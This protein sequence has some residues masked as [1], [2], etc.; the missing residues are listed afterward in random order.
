MFVWFAPQE[1]YSQDLRSAEEVLIC[2]KRNRPSAAVL[3]VPT[4]WR[5]TPHRWTYEHRGSRVKNLPAKDALMPLRY[6]VRF[7][8]RKFACTFKKPQHP[9]FPRKN[10]DYRTLKQ[11]G[12]CDFDFIP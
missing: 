10:I 8:V 9:W 2:D 12:N 3:Y 1:T 11:V 5:F 7:P 6:P 4:S